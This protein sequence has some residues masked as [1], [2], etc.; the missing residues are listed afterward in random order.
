M[1]TSQACSIC[2]MPYFV[3][4]SEF[5]NLDVVYVSDQHSVMMPGKS[6]GE[7]SSLQPVAAEP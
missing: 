6:N 1:V 4:F 7:S 3:I 2:R 5:S